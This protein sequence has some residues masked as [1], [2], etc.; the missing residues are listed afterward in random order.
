MT[1]PPEPPGTADI[2]MPPTLAIGCPLE[3]ESE[4]KL[5]PGPGFDKLESAPDP[6]PKSESE[7][8]LPLESEFE[9]ECKLETEFPE[10]APV[11]EFEPMESD[12]DE[13]ES[14]SKPDPKLDPELEPEL[15]LDP[16]PIDPWPEESGVSPKTPDP[17]AEP[18]E[19]EA[20]GPDM[21]PSFGVSPG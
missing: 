18:E 20:E 3:P 2:G 7:A 15:E 10:I 14:E 19:L 4:P 21:L 6:E 13:S 17:E 11:P 16:E 1:T 9:P 5:D 8:E 12:P